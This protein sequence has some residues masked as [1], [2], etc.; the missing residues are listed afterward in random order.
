[1]EPVRGSRTERKK[2]ENKKK[3][4][5]V[6]MD[7]F[8]RQGFEQTTV[9]QIAE[10]ADIAIGTIYNHFPAKEAIIS[11]HVQ[12]VI[13][14]QG[15][16]VIALI[17]QLPDTRSRLIEALRKSLEWMQIEMNK[18]IYERYIA[19]RMQKLVQ[20][21]RDRDPGL[22]SGLGSILEQ[23]FDLGKEAGEIR[24][25]MPSQ[26]LAGHLDTM[27]CITAAAWTTIPGLFSIYEAIEKNVDLFL[28]GAKIQRNNK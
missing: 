4:I 5:A 25:D 9:E 21:F 13:K 23:I 8:V 17:Q 24:E 3:I 15:P 6:A 18:D 2:E 28:D 1:M 7:L 16:E 27:H 26:V 22:S 20:N 14:A 11:E 10:E 19:Y 12:K